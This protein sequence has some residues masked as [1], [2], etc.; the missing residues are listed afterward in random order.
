MPEQVF[1]V[2]SGKAVC[3]MAPWKKYGTFDSSRPRLGIVEWTW[4]SD[5]PEA[6]CQ[7]RSKR[8]PGKTVV[9]TF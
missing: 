6:R 7:Y 5:F 2:S 4:T 8:D 3:F 1:Q 9:M